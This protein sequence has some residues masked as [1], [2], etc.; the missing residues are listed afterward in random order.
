MKP[1]RT[2]TTPARRLRSL[3]ETL[4]YEND[5]I[6]YKFMERYKLSYRQA[7]DIFTETKRWLWLC[8]RA[9]VKRSA[10]RSLSLIG[11]KEMTVID[12]MWHTFVL[13]TPIYEQF[14]Q[15]YLGQF[16]HHM[17]STVEDRTQVR[18]LKQTDF[19]GFA[20][21]ELTNL[22]QQLRFAAEELGLA[23]MRKWFTTYGRKYAP[24]ILDRLV[25]AHQTHLDPRRLKRGKALAAPG[26]TQKAA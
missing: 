21:E 25:L 16:I 24:E 13:F 22:R 20:R 19:E 14:C 9:N 26:R 4:A 11:M 10:P 2:R 8:A 6:V 23:T 3:R 1:K 5:W 7:N 17:P 18:S 15:R 12:E